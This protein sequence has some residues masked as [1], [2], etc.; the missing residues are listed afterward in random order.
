[1]QTIRPAA[2]AGMFYPEAPAALSGAVRDYLAR[3]LPRT[4]DKSAVPKALIVPHAGYVYSGPIAASAYARIATGRTSIRRVVLLGP[5]HR[6]PIRGLA[7]PVGACFRHAARDGRD[8]R[9]RCGGRALARRRC[10]GA[11]PRTR[12]STRSRCS[13]PF[14]Q[15]MLDE[16]RIVP[17]AVGDADRGRSRRGDRTAV[18][19]PGDA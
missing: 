2:V 7:L 13:L 9:D 10:A 18:G 1:M 12:S 17:F 6:V 8:R 14:L 3:A 11:K 4:A 15:T 5:V 19:R 16:F